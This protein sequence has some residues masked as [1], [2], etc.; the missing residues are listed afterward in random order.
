L[1]AFGLVLGLPVGL[2]AVQSLIAA[3]DDVREV[4]MPAVAAIAAID[5]AVALRRQ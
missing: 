4:S 5:P 2:L 1:S 3:D